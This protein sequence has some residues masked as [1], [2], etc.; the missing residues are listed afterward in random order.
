MNEDRR[1]TPT[2]F[3]FKKF[4]F[5]FTFHLYLIFSL[6]NLLFY[7][8]VFLY[9]SF[10]FF[11]SDI[12]IRN[13]LESKVR[14]ILKLYDFEGKEKM[15]QI[16]RDVLDFYHKMNE[17]LEIIKNNNNNS[18]NNNNISI[19]E[20]KNELLELIKSTE[21]IFNLRFHPDETGFKSSQ[22]S[23]QKPI[24]SL[25]PTGSPAT[26]VIYFPESTNKSIMNNSTQNSSN[27]NNQFKK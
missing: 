24:T 27:Q 8:F 10:L 16:H 9:S 20:N 17:K 21:R 13:L 2:L 6:I 25:A 12:N 7:R 5:S 11:S 4:P 14:E 22:Y 18:I 26:G 19:E 1:N 15:I 23:I 3:S